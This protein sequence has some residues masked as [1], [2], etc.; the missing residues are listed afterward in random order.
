MQAVETS[1]PG[2]P[3]VLRVTTRPV[4]APGAGEVL[5]KVAAAGVNGPDMMQRKGLYPPPAGASDLL[6]LEVSGSVVAVGSGS[7]TLE[8]RRPGYGAHQRRRLRRILRGRR[9]ALPAVAARHRAH[10]RGG[11]AGNLLYRLEQC[12]HRRGTRRRRNLAGARRRG[13][14]RQHR[15]PTRQSVRR[16][17]HRHRQPGAALRFLPRAWARTPWSTTARRT[18]WKSC[19]RPAAPT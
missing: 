7:T 3:E 8:G 16:E 13:R 17:S 9:A 10:R 18:S 2:G 14:H 19:A 11:T 6:G 5:I 12:V 1:A 15:D 4:P